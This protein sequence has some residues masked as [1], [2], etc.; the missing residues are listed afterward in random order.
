MQ[1]PIDIAEDV[2]IPKPQDA[3]A[4]RGKVRIA[5][6]VMCAICVLTAICLDDEL[7]VPTEEID[8]IWSNWVLTYEL[9]ATQSPVTQ[10]KP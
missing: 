4:F 5:N 1:Y 3:I 6:L 8:H 2:R 10:G 9:E 7:A